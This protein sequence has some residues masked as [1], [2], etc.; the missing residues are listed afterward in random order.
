M[1]VLASRT[2]TPT[3]TPSVTQSAAPTPT[4]PSLGPRQVDVRMAEWAISLSRLE[5]KPGRVTFIISNP[6]TR[7]HGFEIKSEG[8]NRGPG[9]ARDERQSRLIAPGDT[10]R[11]TVNLAQ[12]EYEI[13]CYV[14]NH[15]DRGMRARLL[16]TPNP[17][18]PPAPSVPTASTVTIE[19]FEF[20]PASL[21]VDAGTEVVWTNLDT[22]EHTVTAEG[23]FDSDPLG[24]NDTFAQ[25]FDAAGTIEYLC[26]IHPSMTGEVVVDQT[27]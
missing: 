18:E 27:A 24:G 16:V 12:G 7:T 22:T 13:E 4:L 6:G 9:G 25:T 21:G 17:A 1:L 3:A 8:P 2:S 23:S 15:D 5:V 11:M 20:V 26:T 14:G 10:V 19:G